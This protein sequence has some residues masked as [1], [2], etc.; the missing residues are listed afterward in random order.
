MKS[1]KFERVNHNIRSQSNRP[2][3]A[4]SNFIHVSFDDEVDGK[5]VV[6]QTSQM[7]LHDNNP[8]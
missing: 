7:L 5:E 3:P 4:A 1:C 2:E 6:V 8:A